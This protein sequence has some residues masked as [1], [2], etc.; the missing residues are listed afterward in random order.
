MRL[1]PSTTALALAATSGLF[2]GGTAAANP[3]AAPGA[4]GAAAVQRIVVVS[5]A[6]ALSSPAGSRPAARAAARGSQD[7]VVSGA[8]ARGVSLHVT[9]RT[10]EV[11]NALVVDVPADEVDELGSVPGVVAVVEPTSVEAPERP[12]P[13]S[14]EAVDSLVDASGSE[15]EQGRAVVTATNLTGVPQA[16][17]EGFT[18]AGVTVGVIDSGVAYDHPALGGGGFPNGKVIGGYDFADEDA[19]PYDDR[20]GPAA[21]HGTHV[22]GIIAGSDEHMTG[23]APDSTLRSYR[24][25]GTKNQA[26]D[27]IIL[28]A[29]DRAAAD[30]VDVVNMSLGIKGQRSNDVL[31]QAVNTL[32]DSGTPVI[33]ALGNGYAGPFNASSPGVA[34]R[35]I[36]VGSTYND[37]YPYLAFEF[38]DGGEAI[39]YLNTGQP[40]AAPATGSYPVV[41]GPKS[42]DPLPAGS[43]AGKVALFTRVPLGGSAC[44]PFDLSRVIQA[45]GAAGALWY[46]TRL[47]GAQIPATNYFGLASIPVVGI[48]TPSAERILAAPS[49]TTLTWGANYDEPLPADVAGTMDASSSWGPGHELEFKPDVAAP[50]GYILSAI[51]PARG[52]YGVMSGTSM[53]SPHVAGVVA[54]MLAAK[55]GTTPEAV[56]TALQNTTTPLHLTGDPERGLHPLAQQG[57]GRVDAPRAIAEVRGGASVTPSELP[58]GDTE[59]RRTVRQITVHNPTRSAVTYRI[60]HEGAVSAAPPYTAYWTVS[61]AHASVSPGEPTVTVAAFGHSTTTVQIEEPAG[62]PAGTLYGGWV[63]LTPNDGSVPAL[64][65]P[66][67]G[68]AGDIDAVS[69]INSSFTAINP[70]L[71]NPALRPA[72]FSFGK[73]VPTTL[74]L[75]DASSTND[76]AWVMLSHG[77]PMLERVRLQALDADGRVVATPVDQ[78]WVARNSGVG[79]GVSFISWDGTLTDGSPAPAGTYRMR[80]VFDKAMGDPDGAP[81]SESWTSPE[82]TV[83]R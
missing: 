67:Q 16:H 39:P 12:T 77:Y 48:S 60:G 33:V 18:G 41:E 35:A 64:R 45:A 83:R 37:R 32:V 15:S 61:D 7:V 9:H 20:F 76:K 22:A 42:C 73:S 26:T 14:A 55:P 4:S 51:P 27:A 11:A 31:S 30:G 2:V 59:G 50:G 66:Y 82:V 38:A 81:A 79:T 70:T 44:G 71:D 78:E 62:V 5:G 17:R 47:S 23:V 36:G 63:T 57:A 74:D 13:L 52:S 40:P 69:A 8:K 49:G 54:L 80:L 28:A 21:G 3:P 43:L 68:V 19:D 46:D 53:A 6:P 25:F 1:L 58:L 34:D 65:V 24:V 10:T 29:L 56:R 72:Y 75:T